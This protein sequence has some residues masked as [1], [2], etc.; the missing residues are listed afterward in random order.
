MEE[1]R[2]HA[3]S[4]IA[5]VLAGIKSDLSDERV[6][7][8]DEGGQL[9]ESFGIKFLETSAKENANVDEVFLTLTRDISKAL[10][11]RRS[12]RR[13][14]TQINLRENSSKVEINCFKCS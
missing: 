1:I 8:I 7:S 5:I 3:S 9:A 2:N 12:D 10:C 13:S 6:V 11:H 14:S 4:G